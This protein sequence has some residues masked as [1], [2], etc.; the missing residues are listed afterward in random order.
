MYKAY[1]GAPGQRKKNHGQ[2]PG[3][4]EC[5]KTVSAERTATPDVLLRA[6]WPPVEL[7][8][9]SNLFDVRCIH[10]GYQKHWRRSKAR[11]W[12]TTTRKPICRCMQGTAHW[13]WRGMEV[14]EAKISVMNIQARWREGEDKSEG[15]AE[16]SS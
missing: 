4:E 13:K 2:A 1:A 16:G 3:G 5:E 9:E 12:V 8:A 15:K 7:S 14:R 6:R 11:L 10:R